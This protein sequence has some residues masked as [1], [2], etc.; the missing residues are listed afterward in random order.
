MK[1]LMLLLILAALIAVTTDSLGLIF[2]FCYIIGLVL[3][4]AFF[5][6]IAK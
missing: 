6:G 3:L 2:A 1:L 4:M 5:K